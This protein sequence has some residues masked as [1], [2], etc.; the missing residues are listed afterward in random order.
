MH[1]PFPRYLQLYAPHRMHQGNAPKRHNCRLN[2]RA[3]RANSRRPRGKPVLPLSRKC[4]RRT[5]VLLLIRLQ[6]A[7]TQARLFRTL[8]AC[9]AG[10]TKMR[11]KNS[12]SRLLSPTLGQ[13]LAPRTHV[14]ESLLD[15]C[16]AYN[17]AVTELHRLQLETHPR[18][19]AI[20]EFEV[21]CRDI[22]MRLMSCIE[23]VD[24]AGKAEGPH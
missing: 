16:Q 24:R 15:L 14:L 1:I 19:D 17:L 20:R 9:W 3:R 22:E 23:K 8:T 7:L 11:I 2:I 10:V 21:L 18:Q 6:S 12:L 4:V 13:E 5:L